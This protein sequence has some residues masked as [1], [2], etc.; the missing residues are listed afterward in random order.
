MFFSNSVTVEVNFIDTKQPIKLMKT[1]VSPMV[2]GQ[3]TFSYCFGAWLPQLGSLLPISF[4]IP[5]LM[6]PL[7]LL[8]KPVFLSMP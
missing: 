4:I 5:A 2:G 8:K 3:P 6:T 7:P 1:K